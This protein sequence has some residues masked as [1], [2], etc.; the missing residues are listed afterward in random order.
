MGKFLKRHPPRGV[1]HFKIEQYIPV[2]LEIDHLIKV[3]V[4]LTSFM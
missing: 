3:K 4:W 1:S 2:Y